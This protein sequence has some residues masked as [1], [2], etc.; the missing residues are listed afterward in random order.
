MLYLRKRRVYIVARLLEGI[1][2]NIEHT[3]MGGA[4]PARR[5]HEVVVL[6]HAPAGL[7]AGGER[8][9]KSEHTAR[10]K[11]R[12]FPVRRRRSPLSVFWRSVTQAN[13][14]RREAERDAQLHPLLEAIPREVVRVP[15]QSLAIEDFI[16]AN[17]L[18]FTRLLKG[19]TAYPMMSAAAVRIY[20]PSPSGFSGIWE[21]GKLLTGAAVDE[22]EEDILAIMCRGKVRVRGSI[23]VIEEFVNKGRSDGSI[24]G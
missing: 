4:Y 13:D 24:C 5:D 17:K 18:S 15:V 7:D 21:I 3:V 8:W 19:T 10:R 1:N 20:C 22:D 14:H 11:R 6:H 9:V 12:T 23:E 2:I 16:A